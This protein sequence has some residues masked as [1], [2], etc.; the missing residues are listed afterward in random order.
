MNPPFRARLAVMAKRLAKCAE[1]YEASARSARPGCRRARW[2]VLAAA[3]IYGDIARKSRRGEHA[4]DHRVV[5]GKAS[6]LGWVL[7]AYVQARGKPGASVKRDGLWTR[8][9]AG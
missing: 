5:V 9:V 6:K 1:E 3:G 7:R 8:P 4:W 2:A